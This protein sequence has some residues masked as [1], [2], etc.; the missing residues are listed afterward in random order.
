MED[1]IELRKKL[2]LKRSNILN[3]DNKSE[4]IH[5]KVFRFIKENDYKCFLVYMNINYEVDT[6]PIIEYLLENNYSVYIPHKKNLKIW[7]LENIDDL[8]Y[9]A[10]KNAYLD[11]EPITPTE[12]IDVSITP[13]VAFTEDGKD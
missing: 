5:Q 6:L 11:V 2:E 10:M 7:K 13:G 8:H 1:K 12:E 3:R 9:D 4:L